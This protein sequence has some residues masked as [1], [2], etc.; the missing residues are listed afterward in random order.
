MADNFNISE[1]IKTISYDENGNPILTTSS[2]H[3]VGQLPDSTEYDRKTNQTIQLM[4][5][6]QYHPAMSVGQN[7]IYIAT[8][9]I[10]R[11]PKLTRKTS[12]GLVSLPAA[13]RCARCGKTLC[14]RHS[15]T[16]DNNE[17]YCIRPCA[18]IYKFKRFLK[19]I[20]FR[21]DD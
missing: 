4:D 3:E 19:S 10:C 11:N 15:K 6:L 1:E 21:E 16:L 14:P 13:R 8:C 5:G 18:K 2:T 20:F 12:H 17:S 9:A 7:P